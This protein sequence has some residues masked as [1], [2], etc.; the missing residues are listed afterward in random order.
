MMKRDELGLATLESL[1]IGSLPILM[2]L[3]RRVDLDGIFE[4]H[5][6]APKRGRPSKLRPSDVL[7]VMIANILL[8]RLPL[9]AVPEWLSGFVTEELGID[10]RRISLFNDD[11]LGRTLDLLFE[12]DLSSLATSIVV[13]AIKA[14]Q[15]PLRQLHADSTTVT[16]HGQYNRRSCSRKEPPE[17][18]FG[19][20]KDHRPDLKQL[21]FELG[22]SADGAIPVHFRLH[23]G[24][25]TDDQMHRETWRTLRA[26]VGNASFVYVADSKLCVSQTLR[27]IDEEQGTFLTVIPRS[28]SE[29]GWFKEYLCDHLIDWN[30]VRRETNPRDQH[31]PDIV[32]E[33]FESPQHSKEGF[34]VFWYRSSQK[35][36]EDQNHRYLKLTAARNQI[37][38]L[39]ARRGRHRLRSVASAQ[40]AAEKILDQQRVADLLSVRAEERRYEEYFQE[41]AG[42]PGPN[43][44]YQREPLTF[45]DFVVEEDSEAITDDALTDGLFPLITNCRT[46][47]PAEALSIY[48]YQPFLEK[49]FEQ[50]KSVLDVAPVFLK[51]PERVAALLFL[52]FVALLLYAVTERE[53]RCQM[54]RAGIRELP[55]YPE[56]RL[57]RAPTADLAMS[58]F[59]GYR[60]HRLLAPDQTVLRTFHDPLPDVARTLITLLDVPT[61]PYTPQK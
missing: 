16:M 51:K 46:M 9:Y 19:F 41:G 4:R 2:H 42:R 53:I 50:L 12:S 60:R 25:V 27:M 52:Y 26:L 57:C 36:L 49:R 6:P 8:S 7:R 30:E 48:K 21:V 54:K 33:A 59:A 31:G 32:Y 3:M 11:R 10:R 37:E 14:F 13:A 17:I 23:D 58:I 61:D 18:T 5:L 22:V 44:R 28:R 55:L 34:R 20:N 45:I 40:A 38:A 39:Q 24:N 35:L 29:V 15:I 43:T 56:Q 1:E 47:T